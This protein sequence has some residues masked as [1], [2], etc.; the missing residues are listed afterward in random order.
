MEIFQHLL[1]TTHHMAFLFNQHT[2]LLFGG[3]SW[4]NVSSFTLNWLFFWWKVHLYLKPT[5]GYGHVLS[6]PGIN[7]TMCIEKIYCSALQGRCWK[8]TNWIL[9]SAKMYHNDHKCRSNR[10]FHTYFF[11]YLLLPVRTA[12]Q[13][14][15]L[16]HWG[17]IILAHSATSSKA[18]KGNKFG[19]S[20]HQS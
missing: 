10:D 1:Q 9:V 3:N 6:I 19:I 2:K 16:Y 18:S 12:I 15:C 4:A 17:L 20:L 13:T 5:Q 11:L 7:D 8:I 14:K